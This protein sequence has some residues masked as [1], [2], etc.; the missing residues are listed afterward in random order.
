MDF[1]EL[2]EKMKKENGEVPRPL[3]LLGQ[4]DEGRAMQFVSERQAALGGPAIPQKYKA[5]IALSVGV[6]LDSQTC[7][8]NNAKQAKK[9]GATTEEIIE[10]FSVARFAKSAASMAS[11]MP[12]FEWLANNR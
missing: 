1:K 12:A 8:L 5:L 4:L 11:S 7:I 3:E 10:A 9:A 2:M 6:A